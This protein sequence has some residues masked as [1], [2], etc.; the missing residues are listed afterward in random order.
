VSLERLVNVMKNF[1]ILWVV[2][3]FN[4]EQ[5]FNLGVTSVCSL[6]SHMV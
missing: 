1:D 6:I 3:I 4:P 5:L 2:K